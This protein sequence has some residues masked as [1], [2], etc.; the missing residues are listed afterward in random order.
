MNLYEEKTNTKFLNHFFFYIKCD[1]FGICQ[2]STHIFNQ[3]RLKS[4]QMKS[5]F[6][7][8]IFKMIHMRLWILYTLINVFCITLNRW[9]YLSKWGFWADWMHAEHRN[10][11]NKTTYFRAADIF[12]FFDAN[13]SMRRKHTHTLTY[14]HT[15]LASHIRDTRESARLTHCESIKFCSLVCVLLSTLTSP[16]THGRFF[17]G[18]RCI[19]FEYDRNDRISPFNWQFVHAP[20]RIW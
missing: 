13:S 7:L 19:F 17:N 11:Q 5:H 2:K 15:A 20:Q 18:M 1:Y 12:D 14:G 16:L 3:A 4:L 9:C 10:S 6:V 8:K